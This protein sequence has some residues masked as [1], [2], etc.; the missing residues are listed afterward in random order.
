MMAMFLVA[1]LA[2]HAQ[3]TTALWWQQT[4]GEQKMIGSVDKMR[5][6]FSQGN[7][8][9]TLSDGSQSTI[10]I[11]DITKLYFGLG[12]NAVRQLPAEQA[13]LWSPFT[14]ELTVNCQPGIM[15]NIYDASG[16]C[17]SRTIQSIAGAPISLSTLPKGVYVV[18]AAGQTAKILR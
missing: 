1:G 18:E 4:S 8:V 11:A 12:D 2:V 3:Q 9:A 13:F 16:R 14:Q 5:L 17:V 10:S 7:M 6:T 15:V